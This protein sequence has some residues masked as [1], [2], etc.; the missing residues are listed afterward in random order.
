MAL[1]VGEQRAVVGREG[2]APEPRT[3]LDVF[4]DS[5]TRHPKTVALE[6]PDEVLTY[7]QLEARSAELGRCLTEQCGIGPG[8]RVGVRV[9][10]GTAELYMAILGVLHSGAAYVPVDA[11]DPEA[12]A[13]ST[14]EAA[15]VAAVVGPGL[16]VDG[17][18]TGRGAGRHPSPDDDAW[19]IFTSGSTGLPKGVAV[20]HR[21]AAAFVD[22]EARLLGLAPADRVLAGLSVGFDAS[23]EEM[24]LAW[25][26]GATLVPAPRRLVRSGAELGPWLAAQRISVV[27]T[28]P[29]LAAMWDVDDLGSVR[30]LVLGGEACHDELG[31]RLARQCE[32]WNTYGPTETTVVATAAPVEIGVPIS[33]GYPLDGWEVAVLDD[34]GWPVPEDGVGEL[35]IAGVGLGRYLDARLDAER[36]VAVEALGWSRAYRTGDL[37]RQSFNGLEFIGRKDDQ[38]KIGGRRIEP[39]EIE[40]QLN[41]L[42]GVHQAVVVVRT[43][44]AGDPVLVGYVATDL[45]VG[46]MHEQLRGRLPDSLLPVLVPL[47]TLPRTTSGKVDRKALPWPPPAAGAEVD[48]FSDTERWLADLWE[49]YLGVRPRQPRDD[50]FELGGSSLAAAK[51]ASDLRSRFPTAAVSDIYTHRTLGELAHRLEH[52]GLG[53]ASSAAAPASSREQLAGNV[54]HLGATAALLAFSAP[55]WIWSV[56]FFNDVTPVRG[57]PQVAWPWLLAIWIVCISGPGRIALV[58]GARRLLLSDLRP[59]RYRRRSSVGVRVW[60]VDRL[61][62]TMHMEHYAGTPWAASVARALGTRVGLG[63]RLWTVP[64]PAGLVSIG[65]GATIE[66]DADLHGWWVE[67]PDLVVG[68]VEIGAGARVGTRAVLMPGASVGQRAEVEPGSVVSGTVPDDARWAG[69]PAH[70]V[71]PAGGGWPG[72]ASP[73]PR[74]PR[75]HRLAYAAGLAVRPLLPVISI[76]PG[77]V[78]LSA[79]GVNLFTVF[80]SGFSI[81]VYAPLLAVTFFAT[82]A[83]ISALMVRALGRFVRPGWH[84]DG[85]TAWAVWMSNEVLAGTRTVL[86]PLYA[87]LLTRPWLRLMGMQIGSRSEISTGVG[88]GPLV[89]LGRTDFI[90]DDVVFNTARSKNGWMHLGAVTLDDGVFVGN[91]AI[92]DGGSRLGRSSLVGVQS[93]AP[94]DCPPLTSWFGIPPLEF[95]RVPTAADPA[96]T[97]APPRRLVAGRALAEFFRM[98]VPTAASLGIAVAV[99]LGLGAI[100]QRLGIWAIVGLAPVLLVVAGLVAMTLTILAK[101]A[102][103]GRYRAG[104]HPFWSWF[105]WRDEILNTCHEVLAGA[106]LLELAHG[107]PIMTLYLRLMGASV[108]RDV[109]CDTMNVTEFDVVTIGDGCAANRAS[110]IETHLFHDRVMSIGPTD[111]GMGSTVGPWSVVL[112]ETAV[113]DGCSVGGRS[114]VLRGEKLPAHT[115]WHGA[116]VVAV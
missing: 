112:P 70:L 2:L 58:A 40:A 106:W 56:L 1:L 32:V 76:V 75:L 55:A 80:G 49:T 98:I 23:C 108:G 99:F 48:G 60:F 115:R 11:E 5:V 10:S 89:S 95:P 16:R 54:R 69:S 13:E 68:S 91:G 15:G 19:V 50:F 17:R 102:I 30:L 105:V 25:R 59:G 45:D 100:G 29:T 37:V 67:G 12:R 97:T 38:I 27:S 92:I 114:V 74:R 34:H 73:P 21:A 101:W 43:T 66:P 7:A 9:P 62:T 53:T 104:D 57:V 77:L 64:S 61:A 33:I 63:A 6:A 65:A 4:A 94:A 44:G 109:W 93:I 20:T 39:G 81:F 90:A 85:R 78:V 41:A 14:W 31:W 79:L 86:F 82:Y 26:N 71:G 46:T 87:S 88:L 110:C 52:Q 84:G 103:M 36:F 22:A 24:W 51:L 18:S 8:D 116:P 47:A 107:S 35:C 42:P 113:G 111:L 28:V 3:L 96:R 72:Q 83:V